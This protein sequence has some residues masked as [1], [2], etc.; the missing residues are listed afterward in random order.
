MEPGLVMSSRVLIGIFDLFGLS[1]GRYLFVPKCLGFAKCCLELLDYVVE[2]NYPD[3]SLSLP[4]FL[5]FP[6]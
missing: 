6:S 1:G 4:F 2:I 5:F 3:L